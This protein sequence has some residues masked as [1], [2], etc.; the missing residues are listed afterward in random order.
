MFSTNI[1][2]VRAFYRPG[3]VVGAEEK[4]F[5]SYNTDIAVKFSKSFSIISYDRYLF[6]LLYII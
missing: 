3:A 6:N 5:L 4:I 1:L 2:C